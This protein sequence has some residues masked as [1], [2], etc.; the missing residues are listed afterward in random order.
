MNYQ[1]GSG[2]ARAQITGEV[3]FQSRPEVVAATLRKSIL[4]G[5]LKPGERLLEHRLAAHF[6]IG[7]PTLRE[8]LKELEVEGFVR[9]SAQK[10]TFVTKLTKHD[11]QK[12]LEVRVALEVLAI[13]RATTRLTAVGFDKLI[14]C[15]DAMSAAA[16]RFDLSTFHEQDMVFHRTIWRA[17]DNDYLGVA[18]E[19]E[20]FVLFAFVLLQR[21]PDSEPEL[22]AA[23][24]QH[25]QII[26]GLKSRDC[27]TARRLFVDSVNKFW[28]R[29]HGV[30]VDEKWMGDPVGEE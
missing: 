4:T 17:A 29:Y 20:V 22:E 11:F 2:V 3:R 25:T 15:V 14:V 24:A 19:R 28:G 1:N 30:V 23:V 9:K 16:L 6:G 10:G 26:E 5:S 13:Q 18:L 21:D 27:V 12:I 8:A 7:Q